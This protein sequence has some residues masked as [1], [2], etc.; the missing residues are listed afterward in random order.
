MKKLLLIHALI[1]MIAGVLFVFRPD[2]ILMTSGQEANTLLMAKLY[3]ILMFS[4]GAVCFFLY[5]IFEYTSVFKKVIMVI[6]AFHLMVAL[7][8]YSGFNQGL[9]LNPGPFGLHIVLA[10]LFGIGYMRELN[11]FQ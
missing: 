6:M 3:A 4:F 7:Q 10:S 2:M 9:V 1:E 8:M 5:G 11:A